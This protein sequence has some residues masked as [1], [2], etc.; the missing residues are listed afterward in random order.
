MFDET[1]T[2]SPSKIPNEAV[3][4]GA[5]GVCVSPFL[6]CFRRNLAGVSFEAV[7]R[8]YLA[9]FLIGRDSQPSEHFL[10]FLRC[11]K[12]A[13]MLSGILGTDTPNLD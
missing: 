4:D 3:F 13:F 12:A 10:V 8:V 5:P 6:S 2:T 11:L 7:V 9:V 1:E